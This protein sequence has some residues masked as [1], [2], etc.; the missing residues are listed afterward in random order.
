MQE[1]ENKYVFRM[2]MLKVKYASRKYMAKDT[3]AKLL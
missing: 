2:L 1:K 3:N